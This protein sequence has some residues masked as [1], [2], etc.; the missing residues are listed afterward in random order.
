MAVDPNFLPV[1]SD[2][3]E[4]WAWERQ[5]RYKSRPNLSWFREW[6]PFDSIISPATYFTAVSWAASPGSLTLA[7]PWTEDGAFEP[8][9][10][11]IIGF[12]SHPDL[13]W[14]ASMR[15]GEHFITRVSFLTDKPPP[16]Q[17]L[18]HAAWDEHCVTRATSAA[19][20]RAAFTSTLR[21]LL[22]SWGFRGHI[23]M[24]P[25]G[26]MLHCA[27]LKPIPAHHEQLAQML[28]QL[29]TAALTAD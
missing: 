28:P 19:H 18:G 25:N 11:T 24:R 26:L 23:E 17:T 21:T 15:S 20:A 4:R 12:A 6:E 10:R 16:E 13:R 1:G 2:A 14:R 22:Q 3:I 8:M 5:L 27:N 29:V 9:D 7:E